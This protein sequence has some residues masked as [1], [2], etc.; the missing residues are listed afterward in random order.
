MEEL[1]TF[2]TILYM[3]VS[4]AILVITIQGPEFLYRKYKQF[5]NRKDEQS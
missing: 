4:M 2:E 5:K 1:S 3:G